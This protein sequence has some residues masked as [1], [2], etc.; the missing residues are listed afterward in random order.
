[1]RKTLTS[2]TD[3]LAREWEAL[4]EDTRV[5]V[6]AGILVVECPIRA[7]KAYQEDG[8]PG[9]YY[10]QAFSRYTSPA[11]V[12]GADHG[13]LTLDEAKARGR[14]WLEE[15]FAAATNPDP[16]VVEG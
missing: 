2:Q 7:V 15:Q 1:M 10:A 5:Y 16:Q 12:L 3:G 4:L 11:R 8:S 9:A 6:A 14:A 13:S